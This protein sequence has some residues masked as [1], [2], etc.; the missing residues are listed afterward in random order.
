MLCSIFWMNSQRPLQ[1]R[2]RRRLLF[3]RQNPRILFLLL[4]FNPVPHQR[5]QHHLQPNKQVHHQLIYLRCLIRTFL[6]CRITT[7]RQGTSCRTTLS[8]CLW[9]IIWSHP[10]L[11]EKITSTNSRSL[12]NHVRSSRTGFSDSSYRWLIWQS[13]SKSS[14]ARAIL[15]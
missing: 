8:V 12:V 3:K 14:R 6:R 2:R 11:E 9:R 4:A 13:L 5:Q 7:Y 15:L 10:E 1:K